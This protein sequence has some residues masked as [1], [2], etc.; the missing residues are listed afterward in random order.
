MTEAVL[1]KDSALPMLAAIGG[2]T[3][4]IA[5]LVPWL[6]AS[7]SMDYDTFPASNFFQPAKVADLA[8]SLTAVDEDEFILNAW[9]WVGSKI[10]YESL[11]SDIDFNGNII[12]CL[13]CYTVEETLARGMG[14]CVN[15]S[16]LLASILLNRLPANRVYMIIG[17]FALDG[18]GGHSWILVNRSD[19]AWYLIEATSPPKAQPW[20]PVS[21]MGSIYIPYATFNAAD[22]FECVNS[23]CFSL[24]VGEC[25][26]GRR[27]QE[28]L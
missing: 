3:V 8:E 20:V 14:N 22:Y 16:A 10:T 27:I 6:S 9:N 11:P 1:D 4:A 7:G 18:V 24:K 15:K 12:T 17:G 2:L 13:Y 21:S 28:L 5:I 25:N 23:A 19:G 26:C